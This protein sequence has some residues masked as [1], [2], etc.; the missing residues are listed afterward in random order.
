[1]RIHAS[2][3]EA[4][5][6]YV[7]EVAGVAESIDASVLIPVTDASVDAVLEHRALLPP[8][9]VLP[10]ASLETYRAAS[11]KVL[12]HELAC[13]L[14]IGIAESAVVERAGDGAPGDPRLYPGVVKPHRS[15]VGAGMR[16]KTGVAFVDSPEDCA[17]VL[18]SLPAD[19]FPVLVQRRVRGPGEGIFLA[20]WKGRTIARFAH[21]RLREKPPAGGVSVFRESIEADAAV[22]AACEALLDRLDWQGVAMIEGKR[23]LDDNGWR[24]MEINGRFWGSLQLAIDSGVD[25]PALL[26]AAAR[27]Q[28]G[29]EVPAWRAGVRLRWEWGDID[30]LLIRLLRSATRLQLGPGA[31]GR[32][33]TLGAFMSVRP[34]RDRLEIFRAGD[35]LPFAVESLARL[36]V[37]R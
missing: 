7:R 29:V 13:A 33:A 15:V 11:D 31:P 24:V 3:L 23:D 20:R 27:G 22:L 9:L 21:R 35:P 32:L 19:S 16:S 30:H 12:V 26:V 37:S 1:V 25:F 10:L 36:G 8:S 14:G 28:P 2:A 5:E 6:R 18:A 4:P 17:R 34:G